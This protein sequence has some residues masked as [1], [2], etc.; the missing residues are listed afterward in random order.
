[1]VLWKCKSSLTS[2]NQWGIK[3]KVHD[4]I[5]GRKKTLAGKKKDIIKKKV[6]GVI[7]SKSK[8]IRPISAK[9]SG[10]KNARNIAGANGGNGDN[11][12]N[13]LSLTTSGI[14]HV[15]NSD[16]E[17]PVNQLYASIIH[18]KSFLDEIKAKIPLKEQINLSR[19]IMD[20]HKTLAV[21][22]KVWGEL[23]DKYKDKDDGKDMYLENIKMQ[24]TL[25]M[26]FILGWDCDCCERLL[27][28]ELKDVLGNMGTYKVTI[29]DAD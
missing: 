22:I 27:K 25:L 8:I 17:H 29:Q 1:M 24:S 13:S 18:V 19:D 2:K 12:G 20:I 6:N 16:P 23:A 28:R 10:V 11:G 26:N 3:I 7:P 5:K 14:K 4:Y 21:I 15:A 9:I